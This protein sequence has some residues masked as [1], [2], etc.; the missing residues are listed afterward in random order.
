M[1]TVHVMQMTI[2]QIVHV[3]VMLDGGMAAPRPMLM[4]MVLVLF[5]VTHGHSPFQIAFSS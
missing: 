2:V 5:A 3:P 4:F 1:I